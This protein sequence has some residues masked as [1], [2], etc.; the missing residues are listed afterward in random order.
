M[1]ASLISETQEVEDSYF[2]KL[3]RGFI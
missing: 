2:K 3:N 1:S